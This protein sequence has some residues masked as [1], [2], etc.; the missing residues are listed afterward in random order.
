MIHDIVPENDNDYLIA[1]NK[2]LRKENEKMRIKIILLQEF[3]NN[4]KNK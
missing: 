1:S 3:I 4:I 2:A